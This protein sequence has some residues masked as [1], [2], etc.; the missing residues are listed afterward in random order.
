MY[1]SYPLLLQL[2]GAG[3]SERERGKEVRN[4]AV[5][6]VVGRAVSR[7]C[8]GRYVSKPSSPNHLQYD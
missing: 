6:M 7:V 2:A 1:P 5:S 3:L 8:V 4:L